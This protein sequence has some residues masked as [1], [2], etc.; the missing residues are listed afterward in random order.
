MN[1]LVAAATSKEIAPFLEEY[2][3]RASSFMHDVDVLITGI[4]LTAATYS[5]SKQVQL[6]RPG[7]IVQAGIAGCFDTTIPLGTVVVVKKEI[8]ADQAVAD[9]KEWKTVYDL[10]LLSPNQRPYTNKWLVNK[11][12]V[13]KKI[14]LKKVNAISI[15]EI[16]TSAQ[17][18]NWYRKLFNPVTESMEGAALHY[19]ALMENIPFV[20]LRGIS[21]YIGERDKANW[22]FEDSIKNLN[23]QLSR[24]LN[25]SKF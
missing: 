6:K 14:K 18:I 17:K 1:I 8:I 3:Y 5:I 16:S 10:D 2:R 9:D 20:Q 19:V 25:S 11:S 23:H 7:L 24:L 21:N 22:N 12:D 4:G 15:N 13:L